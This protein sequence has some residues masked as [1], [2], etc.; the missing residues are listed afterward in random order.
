MWNWFAGFAGWLWF[1]LWYRLL[2]DSDAD[3]DF[4]AG[5][6]PEDINNEILR[7]N[8]DA[9]VSYDWR[10]RAITAQ[11]TGPWSS[12]FTVETDTLSA[13][14]LSDD[15]LNVT[16]SQDDDLLADDFTVEEPLFDEFCDPLFND[17][18]NPEFN[19]DLVSC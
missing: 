7:V 1:W 19:P 9:G 2:T 15:V 18:C 14:V 17:N 8:L 13:D 10:V 3:S 5:S 16:F 12:T 4:D 11:D 6:I